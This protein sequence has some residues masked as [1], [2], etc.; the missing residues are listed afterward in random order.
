MCLNERYIKTKSRYLSFLNYSSLVNKIACGKCAECREKKRR[1]Y[2]IRSIVEAKD[3]KGVGF[4]YMDTLTY[5]VSNRPKFNEIQCFSKD[6]CRK[7][8]KR[9]HITLQREG[10]D[11]TYEENGRMRN[12]LHHFLV[13]EYGEKRNAPH[14]HVIFFSKVPNLSV[15][16]L[17]RTV[18]ETW[19]LGWNNHPNEWHKYIVNN[20]RNAVNYVCKYVNKDSHLSNKIEN[21][22]SKYNALLDE[23]I[24]KGYTDADIPV[25]NVKKVLDVYNDIDSYKTI[26]PF[27]MIS[28]G[29]GEN[30]TKHFDYEQ[31]IKDGF[32]RVTNGLKEYKYSIP[33]YNMRKMFYDKVMSYNYPNPETLEPTLRFLPNDE[34][35]RFNQLHVEDNIQRFIDSFN[36][37]QQKIQQVYSQQNY[38]IYANTLAPLLEKIDMRQYAIYE[39]YQYGKMFALGKSPY[40]LIYAKS[41]MFIDKT[42]LYCT[43]EFGGI[44]YTEDNSSTYISYDSLYHNIIEENETTDIETYRKISNLVSRYYRKIEKGKEHRYTVNNE[45]DYK[46]KNG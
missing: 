7:F 5:A 40:D 43:D 18:R 3:T 14:Y 39:L 2:E 22:H 12:R 16:H 13:C 9:L 25:Q 45:L 44:R 34:Y 36:E 26:Y 4:V 42:P 8:F 6:D 10:Y 46:F 35:V 38:E 33:Q 1:D 30:L 28:Q 15:E 21:E 24:R 23:L 17:W 41:Q 11:L 29:F 27:N 20:E 32:I 37:K 31:I 19:K